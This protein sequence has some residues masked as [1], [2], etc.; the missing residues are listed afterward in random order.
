MQIIVTPISQSHFLAYCSCRPCSRFMFQGRHFQVAG[1][2]SRKKLYDYSQFC[3]FDRRTKS[4]SRLRHRLRPA[5]FLN[6]SF[7][8]GLIGDFRN[9][10]LQRLAFE[11]D[12]F[13]VRPFHRR[14]DRQPLRQDF[15]QWYG[16]GLYRYNLLAAETLAHIQF[17]RLHALYR[18]RI[19]THFRL[20][21]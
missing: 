15:Q 8:P 11:V 18:C 2:I 5:I 13:F 14:V 1:P 20:F 12:C 10:L 9:F 19:D 7:R 3:I 21:H 6:S 4:R 17:S 16:Q